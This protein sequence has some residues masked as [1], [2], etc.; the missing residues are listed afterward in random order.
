ML[1]IVYYFI[2]YRCYHFALVFLIRHGDMVFLS[3]E[4]SAADNDTPGINS[5]LLTSAANSASLT[6][7]NNINE[8]EIDVFLAKQNGLIHREKDPQL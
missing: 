8:D 2:N 1:Y 6:S 5:C 7:S 4:M 3:R